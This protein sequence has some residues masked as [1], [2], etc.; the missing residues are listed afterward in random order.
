MIE[1]DVAGR[2]DEQAEMQVEVATSN[3]QMDDRLTHPPVENVKKVH[4][5]CRATPGNHR[6]SSGRRGA[7]GDP[8]AQGVAFR[9]AQE[10]AFR[11]G[12]LFALM[13]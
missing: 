12:W 8:G 1:G 5:G 7:A 11:F 9:G 4:Q 10:V 2:G 13:A 3:A 6:A